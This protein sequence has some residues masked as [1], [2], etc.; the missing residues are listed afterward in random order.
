MIKGSED[1]FVNETPITPQQLSR[2]DVVLTSHTF[3]QHEKIG[4]D[5]FSDLE[6]EILSSKHKK[7]KKKK[8]SEESILKQIHWF[9]VIVDEGFVMF[10]I[11]I[12]CQDMS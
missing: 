7:M 4:S 6:V 1:L 5:I 12:M 2:F 11:L 3:L 9:R 10:C 8:Q